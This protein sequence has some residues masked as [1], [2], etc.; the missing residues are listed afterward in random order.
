MNE[1]MDLLNEINKRNI[2]IETKLT[3][4]ANGENDQGIT[5][6]DYS[7]DFIDNM[8]YLR[9]V[10]GNVSIKQLVQVLSTE[11]IEPGESVQIFV[12]GAYSLTVG[13]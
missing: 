2:R 3:R 4:L 5:T 9:V 10:S 8:W 6:V 13:V 7:I 1:A 12:N 11:G